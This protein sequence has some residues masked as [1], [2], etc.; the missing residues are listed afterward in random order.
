MRFKIY[1][2][3]FPTKLFEW[4][5]ASDQ[6]SLFLRAELNNREDKII[7][8]ADLNFE[9][10]RKTRTIFYMPLPSESR[11][12]AKRYKIHSF[13]ERIK[14]FFSTSKAQYEFEMYRYL[15]NKGLPVA[16]PVAYLEKR[17]WNVLKESY[18]F[19]TELPRVTDLKQFILDKYSPPQGG[20]QLDDELRQEKKH[21]LKRLAEIVRSLH[22]ANFWH[23]DLHVGNVLVQ[24]P[25]MEPLKLY[26]TDF[27]QG[28]RTW[29]YSKRKVDNVA[30]LCYSL[31]LILPMSDIVRFINYY[32]SLDVRKE[33]VRPFIRE[34]L[35]IVE[36]IRFRHWQSRA[37]R[38]L[39]NSSL[40]AV[41][42]QS[43][44]KVYHRRS[45]ALNRIGELI[46][47]HKELSKTPDKLFKSTPKRKISF[48]PLPATQTEAE[49]CYVKEYSYSFWNMIASLFRQHPAKADWFSHQGFNVRGMFVP[50]ALAMVEEKL[51]IF[52]T[53]AFII[54]KEVCNSLPSGQY[55]TAR[56]S[57]GVERDDKKRY[58]KEFANEVCHLHQR[59]IFH[60]DLKANNILVIDEPSGE[61]DGAFR[62]FCFLDLDRVKFKLETS[63][64]ERVKNLAQLNAATASV[65]TRADR[66][67][68]FRHYLAGF[69]PI[70]PIKQRELIKDIM[71]ETI[72]RHH[73]WPEA[74][75][76]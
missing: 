3:G 52:T 67:R 26:L 5:V 71:K 23:R 38:C 45:F 46:K 43:G 42:S 54:T 16:Q 55:A 74:V 68:F 11:L 4:Y 6:S 36:K 40:F 33:T 57:G 12:F 76:I 15:R 34:V 41:E 7:R 56:F 1:V 66:L 49:K 50:E 44:Y 21:I 53:R 59:G 30:Q 70:N 75:K 10:D 64:K 14:S 48:L 17:K 47:A 8:T 20:L 63:R 25:E 13:A 73:F 31:R 62:R 51:G 22:G 58:L 18:L 32:R 27:H 65:L 24:T 29:M 35:E 9:R 60:A 28:R 61:R 72:K 19:L 37:R 39:K 69:E 2:P